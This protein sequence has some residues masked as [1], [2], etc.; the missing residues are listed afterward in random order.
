[1]CESGVPLAFC[2]KHYLDLAEDLAKSKTDEAR[3]RASISRAYYAAFCNAR[4]YM[5]NKDNNNFPLRQDHHKYLVNYYK[6]ELDE[7][8]SDVEG[9]RLKL[10]KDLDIMR[11]ARGNVDYREDVSKL[12]NLEEK[13]K[14][15]LRRSKRVISYLERGGF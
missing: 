6:G 10:G 9:I 15:V 13:T 2:W 12:G 3:L 7:S 1:M 8:K 4:N 11:I 14:D 5:L